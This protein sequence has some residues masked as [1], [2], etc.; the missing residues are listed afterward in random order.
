MFKGCMNKNLRALAFVY[1]LL[2]IY[3]I[4]TYKEFKTSIINENLVIKIN[5]SPLN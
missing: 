1:Q 4:T 3:N 2:A 5:P